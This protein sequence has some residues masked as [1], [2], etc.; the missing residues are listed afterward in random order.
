[1]WSKSLLTLLLTFGIPIASSKNVVVEE[2]TQHP[3][4]W[5]RSTTPINPDL[6]LFTLHVG[7]QQQ[8]LHLLDGRLLIYLE[9][10]PHLL[11]SN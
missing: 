7:L 8:N 11:K 1:M 2:R 4:S 5:K 9:S 3:N 10:L 6:T